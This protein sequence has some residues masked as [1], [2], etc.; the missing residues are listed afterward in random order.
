MYAQTYFAKKGLELPRDVS[1]VVLIGP[2]EARQFEPPLAGHLVYSPEAMAE[3]ARH[4]VETDS[5]EYQHLKESLD[6]GWQSGGS[7][8]P[9]PRS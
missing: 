2:L 5:V 7:I 8:G 6:Q 9:P 1:V 4:W 3:Q